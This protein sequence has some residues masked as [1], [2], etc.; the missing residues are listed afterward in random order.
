MVLLDTILEGIKAILETDVDTKDVIKLY[1]KYDI[2]EQGISKTPLCII[3]P[4]LHAESLAE[5]IG[6]YHHFNLPIAIHLLGR[7]YDIPARH[8]AVMDVLDVLQQDV[9]EAIVADHELNSTVLDSS[10]AGIRY[11][12]PTDEYV[13]YEITV[14][15]KTDVE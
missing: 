8:Q 15:V 11:V 2:A 13:G 5:Y 6:S 10:I 14:N 1:R 7:A 3:G 12:R 4:V 9:C